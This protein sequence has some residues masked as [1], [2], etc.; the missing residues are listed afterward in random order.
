MC[1]D[2]FFCLAK[3]QLILPIQMVFNGFNKQKPKGC[4]RGC[5]SICNRIGFLAEEIIAYSTVFGEEQTHKMRW[6]MH[7][8]F[9]KICGLCE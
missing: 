8:F 6:G 4:V 2:L 3:N 1:L 5:Y 9:C 7:I